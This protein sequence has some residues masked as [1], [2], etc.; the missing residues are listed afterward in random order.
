MRDPLGTPCNPYV[1][2][3]S[4]EKHQQNVIPEPDCSP[5]N[6]MV[7]KSSPL[8]PASFNSLST[9]SF[10]LHIKT[11]TAS[12]FK[13]NW[14]KASLETMFYSSFPNICCFT[15]KPQKRM[16]H[17]PFC[18]LLSTWL[19]T[20]SFQPSVSTY[21]HH[22]TYIVPTASQTSLHFAYN[23]LTSDSILLSSSTLFYSLLPSP[24]SPFI[25]TLQEV[26]FNPF[27]RFNKASFI[28]QTW[29]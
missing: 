11:L 15:C 3:V 6:D 18:Y 7:T 4:W 1:S 19:S 23:L 25:P 14:P 29:T 24:P 13:T 5:L 20:S 8:S 22:W 17:L 28:F 2:I 9:A 16:L 21:S 12:T 27:P 26:T 10:Y